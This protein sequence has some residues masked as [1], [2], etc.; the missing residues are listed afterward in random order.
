[1][2]QK[3]YSENLAELEIASATIIQ[4]QPS[5]LN[6]GDLQYINTQ[7]VGL[8]TGANGLGG[9]DT[10]SITADEYYSV[11]AV[12]NVSQPALVASLNH[13]A[14]TGFSLYKKIGGFSTDSSGDIEFI[15]TFNANSE[16]TKSKMQEV[17][18]F[19][20]TG[21]S[22]PT[23]ATTVNHDKIF[24]HR[25]ADK[26]VIVGQYE[27]TGGG[28]APGTGTYFIKVPFNLTADT[29]KMV[30]TGTIPWRHNCGS[31]ALEDN[32]SG[33]MTG[34]MYVV[35]ESKPIRVGINVGNHTLVP[36]EWGASRGSLNDTG[37]LRATF[38]GEIFIEEFAN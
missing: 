9:L 27:Q 17:S 14:P 35:F 31:A 5:I 18:E 16:F 6:I 28:G 25:D 8:S 37:P 1:M 29:T 36:Q 3:I 30:A 26:L 12:P 15:M 33:R 38:E 23:K 22:P 7:N 19:V 10:G 32:G 20:F 21:G 24:C 34:F 4:L 11:Y 13:L 2:N